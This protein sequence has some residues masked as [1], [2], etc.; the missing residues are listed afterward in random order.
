MESAHPLFQRAKGGPLSMPRTRAIGGSDA[1]E[2]CQNCTRTKRR[3]VPRLG[4]HCVEEAHGVPDGTHASVRVRA[5][6]CAC[7]QKSSAL[8]LPA[9]MVKNDL[10]S[11]REWFFASF[12]SPANFSVPVIREIFFFFAPSCGLEGID[13]ES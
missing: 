2:K 9:M 5:H 11:G 7:V 12:V 13:A 3:K 1:G 10:G 6:F 8:D 4:R